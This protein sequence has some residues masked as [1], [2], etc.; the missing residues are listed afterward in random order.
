MADKNTI[1]NWFKTSLIPTQAQFWATWDSF[2]HKD[3][4]IPI[5][6]IEDIEN[7]L[8]EKADAEALSNHFTD[9]TAHAGL[10]SG[11]ED[12]SK[13]G[14]ADGYAPLDEFV[15][16][17]SEYLN[18]VNDLV[19]GGA[20]S[21]LAAEQGK[22]L[23]TQIDGINIILGSDDINLDTLQEIVDAIKDIET[24]LGTILVND[25]TTGGTTKALTAE[26]GKTLK[27]L[28]D[29]LSNVTNVS[30][31]NTTGVEQFKITDNV[32]FTGVTFNNPNK[33]IS[34]D[35][36][37]PL[38]AYLDIVNGNDATGVVENSKKPF[39]TL[40]ALLNALPVYN[41][42]T[43]TIYMKGGVIPITRRIST[44]NLTF[45][46]EK[47]ASLDFTNCMD[48]DGIT[49]SLFV[50]KNGSNHQNCIWNFTGGNISMIC[51]YVGSKSFCYQASYSVI[52]FA[53][54]IDTINW[55]SVGYLQYSNASI[56]LSGNPSFVV[57]NVHISAQATFVFF[58]LGGTSNIEIKN[59]VCGYGGN[60]RSLINR[61]PGAIH[62]YDIKKI[63]K[64]GTNV[65]EFFIGGC[66][67]GKIGDVSLDGC[68]LTP[69]ASAEISFYGTITG[70]CVVNLLNISIISGILKSETY[71]TNVYVHNTINFKNFSG[72]INDFL[73]VG[74]GKVIFENC[75]IECNTNLIKRHITP[76]PESGGSIREDIIAFKGTNT[77]TQKTS[78]IDLLIS[79]NGTSRILLEL[80]GF[81]KSNVST[82]GKVVD[83]IETAFTF[84]EKANERVIRSKKDLVG[85][86]LNPL[87]TYVIDG[88]I[89]LAT[90]EYIEIPIGGLTITGYGFDI[91]QINKNVAGQSIFTSPVGGSG[92]LITK[93]MQ[94]NSGL[95]S[96]FDIQD[97]DGSHAIE[98]N[99]VNFIG[100]ASIGKLK[101]YRQ[102]TGTTCGIYNCSNGFQVSGNW[103]GFKLTNSNVINFLSGGT[104]IRKDVDTLFSNRLYLDVNFSCQTGAKICDFLDSNFASN[105]LLQVVN[106]LVKVN[107]VIDSATTA[108]T[109]PNITPFSEKSYFTNN[110]GIKN[111][112][113][114]PYGL[115]T[116][117]LSTY[118]ND[119]DATTGGI[120]IGEVY[121][122]SITGYFRTRMS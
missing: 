42:E 21:L 96:V 8:G 32:R 85:R 55:Q 71:C 57:N 58:Q 120:Q 26:M 22:V 60:T 105:K 82:Y 34:I 67:S 112:F 25:L 69:Q 121:V 1:K 102:F 117:N 30:V 49:H 93:D 51:N 19:T 2:W 84:K 47:A 100:C 12:K 78:T 54:N 44:R 48:D 107:G 86:V 98:M 65:F 118:A 79:S 40:N 91:S 73:I 4:K 110:I 70:T 90:N 75:N 52:Q 53:G 17:T 63:T 89:V 7:I 116:T 61:S 119:S 104:L 77:L 31:Q 43:F 9:E 72:K 45:V 99:D 113:N 33:E 59:L 14:I 16:L 39:K 29:G 15:K 92:N 122:E 50:L 24:Y 103:S 76:T 108:A 64:V 27:G 80:E 5:T 18:I 114:E 66:T 13:K 36:L 115:K 111:S 11:K 28:I 94:Y 88:S 106:C 87:I 20:T 56:V 23:Q 38:S 37:A 46:S 68:I 95:G 81:L 97:S 41:G 6:A 74:I 109:F 83:Y 62:F 3:E 10:F 101:G 35:A